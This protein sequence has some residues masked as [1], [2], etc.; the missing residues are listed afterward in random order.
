MGSNQLY[1][2][3]NNHEQVHDEYM[4]TAREFIK[5][6]FSPYNDN[7]MHTYQKMIEDV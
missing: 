1:S 6:N 4:S 5:D 2:A 3:I 7:V